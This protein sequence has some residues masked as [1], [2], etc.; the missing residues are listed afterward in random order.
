VLLQ[1]GHLG[2]ALAAGVPSLLLLSGLTRMVLA[3]LHGAPLGPK[4]L[5]HLHDADAAHQMSIA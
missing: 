5:H 3:V 1:L 2:S 4:L